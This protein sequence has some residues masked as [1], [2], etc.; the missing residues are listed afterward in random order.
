MLKH[1][2]FVVQFVR[3]IL[4]VV[5]LSVAW[6][7]NEPGQEAADRTLDRFYDAVS[8]CD[9]A[10]LEKMVDD[11]AFRG[12]RATQFAAYVHDRCAARGPLRSRQV[13]GVLERHIIGVPIRDCVVYGVSAQ[14]DLG[15]YTEDVS[16]CAPRG[17]PWKVNRYE[18]G[19]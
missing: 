12:L 17:G 13:L 6:S 10:R 19:W 14:Y 4:L 7:C 3:M 1:S 5:V 9:V 2:G 18:P 16:L 8:T 11:Q 15:V